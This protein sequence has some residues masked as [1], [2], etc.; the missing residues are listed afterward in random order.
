MLACMQVHLD[1]LLPQL[2]S[3]AES[4]SSRAR[5][6]AAYE[7][8]HSIGLWLV[9]STAQTSQQRECSISLYCVCRNVSQPDSS[10]LLSS[11][12]AVKH[13]PVAG[14]RRST[15]RKEGCFAAAHEGLHSIGLWLVGSMAQTSQQPEWAC[16]K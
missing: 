5:R 2:V 1:S 8:L 15:P 3:L 6:L 10:L 9:G 14:A 7:G 4:D 16:N 13:W 12:T 11:R